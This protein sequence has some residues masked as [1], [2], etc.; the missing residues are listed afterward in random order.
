MVAACGGGDDSGPSP[1]DVRS[2]ARA[3]GP[4]VVSITAGQAGGT[5]IVWSSDG[6]IVTARHVIEGP[7]PIIT[8]K[9]PS[10]RTLDAQLVGEDPNSD[11]AV[12]RVA[13]E[14]LRAATFAQH[15]PGEGETAVVVGHPPDV[16]RRSAG[17]RVRGVNRTAFGERGFESLIETS[18][19]VRDGDSGGPIATEEGVV[20]GITLATDIAA[21]LGKK[22]DVAFGVP[23]PT[24]R[25]V[26]P[27]LLAKQLEPVYL[28]VDLSDLNEETRRQYDVDESRGVLVEF[29]QPDSPSDEGGLAFRDVVTTIDGRDVANLVQFDAALRAHKPADRVRLTVR[30]DGETRELSVVLGRRPRDE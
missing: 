27:R 30:R 29:V 7:G 1:D 24:V 18:A 11:L 12:L 17:G 20:I 26:V 25:S 3:I 9:L 13:A 10:G 4:S 23:A 21:A 16:G 14:G 6:V 8:V 5:G 28:G 15:L 2:I 19:R 22:E